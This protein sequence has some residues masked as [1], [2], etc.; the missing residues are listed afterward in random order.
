VLGARLEPCSIFCTHRMDPRDD[1]GLNRTTL[2]VFAILEELAVAGQSGLR[3]TDLCAQLGTHKSTTSRILATLTQIRVVEQDARGRF[4]LGIAMLRLGMSVYQ[5]LDLRARA[6]GILRELVEVTGETVHMGV[7]EGASVVYIEK[8]EGTNAYQMRSRI[9]MNMPMYSTGLG[10]AILASMDPA[11]VEQILSGEL[12]PRTPHTVTDPARLRAD[13]RKTRLRGYSTDLE[14]NEEGVRCVGAPVLN[15]EGVVVAG[16]SIAGPAFQLTPERMSE[17]AAS[18]VDAAER[19]S[20]EL[21]W[22]RHEPADSL[23]V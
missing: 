5:E 10:K 17:L 19:V 15:H 9:G 6:R 8:L 21:G 7:P 22:A 23:H 2:R 12:V 18:I 11:S 4:R 3:L 16:I 13:L 1:Q 20:A 14:E